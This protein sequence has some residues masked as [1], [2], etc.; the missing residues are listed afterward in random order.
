MSFKF[1]GSDCGSE[2]LFFFLLLVILFMP[3]YNSC[4][5]GSELLFFFLLLVILFV[6][7]SCGGF[8]FGVSAAE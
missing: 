1:G 2:L 4:E 8:S 3:Y 5:N 7:Y 6:P